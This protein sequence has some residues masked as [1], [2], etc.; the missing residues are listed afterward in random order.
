M[1]HIGTE[2]IETRRLI[3]RRFR[4]E[5]AQ[6]MFDN[7]ASDPEVTRYLTWPTHGSPEITA[8]VMREWVEGYA[9]D[10]QY[11]WAMTLKGGDDRPIGD[12]SVIR[13]DPRVDAAE[14][15][16]CMGKAWWGQGLMS[17]ALRAVIDY[18]MGRVGTN[19]VCARHDVRNIGSGRVMEKSGMVYEGTLRQASRNNV[20]ICDICSRS[21]L[22][23]EWKQGKNG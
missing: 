19:R 4:M 10:E 23:C 14:I 20:G 5:D 22:A 1:K 12:I 15:G 8:M 21:I 18:M 17:E 7:W 16:Y 2:T 9:S 13:M 11:K 6:A 3:L